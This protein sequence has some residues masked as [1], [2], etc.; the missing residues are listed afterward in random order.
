MYCFLF[1]QKDTFFHEQFLARRRHAEVGPLRSAACRRRPGDVGFTVFSLLS[2]HTDRVAGAV[3]NHR[4]LSFFDDYGNTK[5]YLG[6]YTSKIGVLVVVCGF[7]FFLYLS[8]T[9]FL[10]FVLIII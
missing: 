3:R 9:V 1:L 10:F 8:M 5:S 7:Y 6:A 4:R 2:L